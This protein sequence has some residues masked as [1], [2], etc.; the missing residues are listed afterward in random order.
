MEIAKLK[1]SL[2][3]FRDDGKPFVAAPQTFVL[4]ARSLWALNNVAPAQPHGA[5]KQRR[6]WKFRPGGLCA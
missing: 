4:S 3:F 5:I 2:A 1:P 6:G